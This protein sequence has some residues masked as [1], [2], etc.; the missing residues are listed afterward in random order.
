MLHCIFLGPQGI[1][2]ANTKCLSKDKMICQVPCIR[3]TSVFCL[4]AS[5]LKDIYETCK[6]LSS[7]LS[8]FQKG[9]LY[10]VALTPASSKEDFWPFTYRVFHRFSISARVGEHRL[11]TYFNFQKYRAHPGPSE[12]TFSLHIHLSKKVI[13][14]RRWNSLPI[15]SGF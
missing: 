14:P 10:Y 15:V 13:M 11:Q 3:S 12:F 1:I 7:L 6:A 5:C 2:F 8:S 9:H 4:V